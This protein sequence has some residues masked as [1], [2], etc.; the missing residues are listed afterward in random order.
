M[1]VMERA[2]PEPKLPAHSAELEVQRKFMQAIIRA[3]PKR[4]AERLIRE[5]ATLLSN[6]EKVRVLLPNRSSSQRRAQANAE[7]EAAQWIRQELP[8]LLSSIP[9]E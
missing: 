2:E 6:E 3:L 4:R 5:L 1:S 9:P 7:D 8:M